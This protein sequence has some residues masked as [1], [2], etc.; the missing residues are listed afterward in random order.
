[1][2]ATIAV[3][4]APAARGARA[5]GRHAERA[6]RSGAARVDGRWTPMPDPREQDPLGAIGHV[7]LASGASACD[8]WVARDLPGAS[9]PEHRGTRRP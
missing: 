1:M 9:P 4:L 2:Q 8:R 5:Q 6:G 3:P 7:A